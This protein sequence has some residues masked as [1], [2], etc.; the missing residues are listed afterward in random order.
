MGSHKDVRRVKLYCPYCGSSL[1]RV[2]HDGR[3]RAYCKTCDTVDYDNPIPATAGLVLNDFRQLLLVRR[4]MEPGKGEWGLPGGFVEADESPETGVIREIQAET[5]LIVRPE[6]LV[7]VVYED[8]AFYGPLIIIGYKVRPE[9]G[10]L[11][12]GDDAVEARYFAIDELPRVAFP[13]H[14]SLIRELERL[15]E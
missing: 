5:G 1:G 6:Q 2:Q 9:G 8:S 11:R 3:E 12:A 10:V 15:E 7:A 14:D 4:G 13:A